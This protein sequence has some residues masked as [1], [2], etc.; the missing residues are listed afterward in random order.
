MGVKI[1]L[2]T[3]AGVYRH[4]DN[5]GEFE[6]MVKLGMKPIDALKAG[7]S[8]DAELFGLSDRLGTLEPAKIADIVAVP[9]DPVRDISVCSR[10]L[11]V[12]KEGVVYR[13]DRAR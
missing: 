13:N 12:M 7:T 10:V 5:G 4:G 8:V 9:G 6:R 2:G 1:A 11:F 3:D